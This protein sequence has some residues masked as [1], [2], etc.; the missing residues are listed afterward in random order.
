METKTKSIL[1][2]LITPLLIVVLF[3][4]FYK[5]Y[6][7]SDRLLHV[8]FY[9]VGQGDSF[10][11]TT[12]QGNQILV[13]GGPGDVI[14]EN[15]AS[16][17]GPFDKDLDMIVLTHAHLDHFEGLISVLGKYKVKKILM[18]NVE[19][20]TNQ[21]LE[22]L[23][24]VREEGAEVIY[25]V[26]GLRIYLDNA[27]VLDILHPMQSDVMRPK[28][29]ADINDT[30]IVAMLRFGKTKLL[31]TGD[32]SM[33]IENKLLD[34][35]DFDADLLKVGHHGSKYSTSQ[36][37]LDEVSPQF[38]IIQLGKDNDYG[39]PAPE[40]IKRLEESKVETYRT[41]FNKNVEFVSDGS[42]LRLQ[43]P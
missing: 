28:K 12:Y 2:Y 26:Q 8:D 20:K 1:K 18:P 43:K 27:T 24:S 38:A 17:L 10:L 21:Y 16:D 15:L 31:L 25:A 5:G 7:N 6:D 36:T 42:S 40:T 9:D 41:D 11:I 4:V 35:F 23:A 13:D 34:S 19:F 3:L 37:F 22:F 29:S 14:L 30:S 33:E 32:A 39:H